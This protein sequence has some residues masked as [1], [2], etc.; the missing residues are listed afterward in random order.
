VVPFMPHSVRDRGLFDRDEDVQP[1][2]LSRFEHWWATPV[3]VVLLMFGFANAGVPFTQIGP[4]TWFVLAA[5]VVGKPVG[6]LIFSGAARLAGASLPSGLRVT[7][8]LV[9]GI[10]ASIGFTVSLFFA[11][12]A[13]PEGSALA[14][15]KM[16]ALLSFL[17]A[18]L[19]LIVSRVL[20]LRTG[21]ES[22]ADVDATRA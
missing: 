19:A 9:V 6:I 8:L 13:F 10:V 18:P 1:D 11:T 17:A 5:L 14:E 3:Q 4:G 22:V 15:T 12:A 20:R 21:I 7:D 16:G 2:T